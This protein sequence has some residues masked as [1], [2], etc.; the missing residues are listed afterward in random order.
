[1]D[2]REISMLSYRAEKEYKTKKN[3]KPSLPEKKKRM[4]HPNW[5]NLFQE[6]NNNRGNKKLTGQTKWLMICI[7]IGTSI[8]LSFPQ[9]MIKEMALTIFTSSCRHLFNSKRL[10]L[11]FHFK[12]LL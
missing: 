8:L 5:M 11:S 4:K 2:P 3:Q 9:M 7:F 1:M 10:E 12:G 6:N